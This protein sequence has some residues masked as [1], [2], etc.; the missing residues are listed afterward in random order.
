MVGCDMEL[1]VASALLSLA[2]LL[3]HEICDKFREIWRAFRD[4]PGKSKFTAPLISGTVAI[5]WTERRGPP[6]NLSRWQVRDSA[7]FLFAQR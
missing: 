7:T 1:P 2:A 3:L 5:T 4:G 6:V